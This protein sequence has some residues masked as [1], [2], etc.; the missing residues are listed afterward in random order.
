MARAGN[1][2]NPS[3]DFVHRVDSSRIGDCRPD[4]SGA[5]SVCLARVSSK[6]GPNNSIGC[7]VGIG[8]SESKESLAR[9][10]KQGESLAKL[11]RPGPS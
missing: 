11:L 8:N 7:G 1:E 5:I 2:K 9:P 10:F 4:P 3:K 6:L